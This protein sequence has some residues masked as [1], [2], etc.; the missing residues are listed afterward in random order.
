MGKTRRVGLFFLRRS[1][2][3]ITLKVLLTLFVLVY[4]ADIAVTQS[5]HHALI[6]GYLSVTNNLTAMDKGFSKAGSTLTATGNCPTSN[7][8]F[9][10][11]PG[12]ANNNITA[13]NIVFIVQVNTTASTLTLRCFTVTLTLTPASGPQTTHTIKLATSS[14]VSAGW[15][16][17]CKFDIGTSL[18][19]SPYSFKVTVQ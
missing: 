5:P 16:I 8:T 2:L 17:D 15:T 4:A 19:A 10:S 3:Y 11:G 12:I 9:T 13:G 6:G 7:V 18:P 1:Q 14:S